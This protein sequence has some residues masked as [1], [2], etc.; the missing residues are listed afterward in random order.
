MDI[1]FDASFGDLVLDKGS[2][3]L[4]QT[5]ENT[6]NNIVG[7]LRTEY[8]DYRLTP[9]RGAKLASFQGL[10]ITPELVVELEQVVRNAIDFVA[11]GLSFEVIGVPI[12][13]SV[14]IRIIFNNGQ[15]IQVMYSKDK[16]LSYEFN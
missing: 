16:G 12:E 7:D 2:L 13:R 8:G 11:P 15:T 3:V 14:Y 10:S 9:A 4:D 6:L 5:F 1:K